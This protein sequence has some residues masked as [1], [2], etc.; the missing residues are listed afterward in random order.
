MAGK[1]V[2]LIPA[3]NEERFIGSVVIK[4]RRFVDDVIVVDDGSSDLT[5]L[6]ADAAGALVIQHPQNMG[7]GVALQTG[8]IQ[9]RRMGAD[10]L[11]MLDGDGQHLPEELPR[12]AEPIINGQADIVIGSRYLENTSSVPRHRIL[13]H[14]I[15]NTIIRVATGTSATD[16]QSGFRAFSAA[17]LQCLN[18]NSSSFSVE[19]E[20]QF[21]A[22]EHDLR[23][24][25]VPI[26]IE[27]NEKPKRP[28][29]QHGLIVLNGRLALVGQYRPLLFFRLIGLFLMVTG[30]AFGLRVDDILERTGQL[31]IGTALLSA[32]FAI[33]GMISL[34]TGIILHSVRALLNS[35]AGARLPGHLYIDT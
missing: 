7:K 30:L 12:V 18:F 21:M 29:V 8:F 3:F 27:Y 28:V 1:T 17:A 33:M 4:T 22:R 2:A 11:V 20:M 9:A 10:L 14:N 34:S 25:E 5:A 15:F 19:S 32:L 16:S 23:L 24:Q 35:F 6:I 31:A 13:G 26:T